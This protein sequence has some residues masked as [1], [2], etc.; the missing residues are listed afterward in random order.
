[1]ST[2]RAI[3]KELLDIQP[4]S[5]LWQQPQRPPYMLLLE[6][7][8]RFHRLERLDEQRPA[9]DDQV[10]HAGAAIAQIAAAD[11][12]LEVLQPVAGGGALRQRQARSDIEPEAILPLPDE[13][14]VDASVSVQEPREVG[15]V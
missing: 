10:A 13:L 8:V 7:H 2:S 6:D 3:L 4:W 11:H 12:A 5:E 15:R 1:M 14:E 9:G